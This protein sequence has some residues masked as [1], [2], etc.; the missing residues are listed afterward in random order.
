MT[1]KL[2]EVAA[3]GPPLRLTVCPVNTRLVE[4]PA[5]SVSVRVAV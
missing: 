2:R 5:E 1:T 4:V 3:L